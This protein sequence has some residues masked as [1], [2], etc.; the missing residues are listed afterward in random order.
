[1]VASSLM[2][3]VMRRPLKLCALSWEEHI[4]FGHVPSR[5]DCWICQE[6]LQRCRPHRR[7]QNPRAGVL[8]LDTAGPL[9]PAYDQGGHLSRYFLVGAFTWAIPKGANTPNEEGQEVE[10][11]EDLPMIEAEEMEEEAV[12]EEGGESAE[13]EENEEDMEQEEGDMEPGGGEREEEKEE[14][15]NG[16]EIK[17]FHLAL[18]M[19]SKKALEVTKTAMDMILRL[20]IDG[21]WVNHIH[22]DQGH[23]FSGHFTAWCRRRGRLRKMMDEGGLDDEEEVL[24]TPDQNHPK[25][26]AREW[27]KW[28][29]SAGEEVHPLLTEKMALIPM[30]ANQV[31]AF[32]KMAKEKGLQVEL[33]P[34]KLV[35]SKK[36]G[37]PVRWVVCGNYETRQADEMNY[38]G[39]ADASARRILVLLSACQHY[40]YYIFQWD[41]VG[42]IDVNT[43][44]LNADM[45]TKEDEHLMLLLPPTFFV[46]RKFMPKDT[47]YL[48]QKAVYGLRRSPRLWADH[49]D[50]TMEGFEVK[51][52]K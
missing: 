2:K 9:K 31:D 4:A 30:D 22:T 51:K 1:M 18:P 39:G 29:A 46:E 8:S 49:R 10:E 11:E 5:K 48:S 37:K 17:T 50:R 33:I 45:V 21:Y 34:S 36:A 28:K 13:P 41:A 15:Q 40:I 6:T 44:F 19:L 23:E 12:H 52:K 14:G 20:R 47:Y 43:A 27:E 3:Q 26:V 24:Q 16:V 25:E 38:S 7:V 35:F 42:I 32:M